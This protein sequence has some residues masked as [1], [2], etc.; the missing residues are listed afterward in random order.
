[1]NEIKNKVMLIVE[2]EQKNRTQMKNFFKSEGWMIEEAGDGFEALEKVKQ[3]QYVVIIL[4]LKM[5]ILG[6]LDFLKKAKEEN[7]N[8]PHVIVISAYLNES[9]IKSLYQA[10]FPLVIIHRLQMNP[11]KIT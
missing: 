5:P 9:S 1:M 11:L 4:D 10:I 6:G 8:L 7:I 2:D 3:N